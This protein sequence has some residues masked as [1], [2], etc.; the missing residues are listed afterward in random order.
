[1]KI[2]AWI[3]SG[4]FL[5]AHSSAPGPDKYAPT[6]TSNASN[7]ARQKMEL[8]G[9]RI[10]RDSEAGFTDEFPQAIESSIPAPLSRAAEATTINLPNGAVARVLTLHDMEFTVLHR[11]ADDSLSFSCV[12]GLAQS[13]LAVLRGAEKNGR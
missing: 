2:L 11:N 12:Q 1:M 13:E 4:F 6:S 5:G 9:Q 10:Y 7:G 8:T 3:L